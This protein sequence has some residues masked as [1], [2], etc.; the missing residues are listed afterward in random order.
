MM[1]R[2]EMLDA[3]ES[4]LKKAGFQVSQRCIARPSCFDFATRRENDLAL[5]KVHCNIGNVSVKDAS[6]FKAIAKRFSAAPLFIC[7]KMRVRPLEDDTVYSRYNMY[8]IT[9]K[10]LEDTVSQKIY[11][12]IEAGP[13][14]YYV[15]LDGDTIRKKRQKQGLSVGKLAE[16]MGISARTL[17]GYERGTAKASVSA[18]YKLEW[19]LGSPLVQPINV[20]QLPPLGTGFFATA[21]RLLTKNR[22]L[23]TVLR[24]LA[25][26][27]FSVACTRRAPFDFIAQFPKRQLNIIGGVPGKDERDIDQ[28][29]E[30]IVSIS[31][32]VNAQ[33][34][35][36]T[37]DEKVP[38]SSIVLIRHRDLVKIERPEDF[39]EQL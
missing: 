12:L 7:D 35:F 30:E 5:V 36:V 22:F 2:A 17:Y 15:R 19:I 32:I 10:T 21:R 29:T 13:G 23:Q 8:A 18:A 33:P 38:N 24:K 1:N 9:P 6:E 27:N 25:Q 39:I 26:C 28:R 3:T 20:F 31:K 14:G 11:P 4:I 37:D 34:V 16:M